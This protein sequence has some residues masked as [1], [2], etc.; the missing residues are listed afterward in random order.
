M[1][2][3]PREDVAVKIQAEVEGD[4]AVAVAGAISKECSKHPIM[5]L[6]AH[7]RSGRTQNKPSYSKTIRRMH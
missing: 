4:D 2:C 6:S 7:Y 3:V 5:A 1:L